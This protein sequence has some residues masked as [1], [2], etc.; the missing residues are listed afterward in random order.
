MKKMMIAVFAIMAA[1][2][3]AKAEEINI[4]FD[5]KF[6]PQSMHEIF[7]NGHQLLPAGADM[8]VAA[9]ASANPDA[10]P[11]PI[12]EQTNY[13]SWWWIAAYEEPLPQSARP[14]HIDAPAGAVRMVAA[15]KT[16]PKDHLADLIL[17]YIDTYPEFVA[18]VM[19]ILK[20][21]KASV[22]YDS[23]GA[24]IMGGG[25][26][27]RLDFA[28]LGKTAPAAAPQNKVVPAIAPG[29]E[30]ALYI[31]EAG[32]AWYAAYNAWNECSSS[33]N[34]NSGNNGGYTG[35]SVQP[36]HQSAWDIQHNI[37]RSGAAY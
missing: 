28:K 2:S 18:A 19:P 37:Q 10:T 25:K 27:A 36:T 3:A 23:K 11:A 12:I 33:D 29:L 4:D 16:S 5:G 1:G 24:R 15:A 32:A 35:G 34:S 8:I 21:S 14:V 30:I 17:G 7:A 13:G 31:V 9:P 22:V 6:K 26:V 20:D